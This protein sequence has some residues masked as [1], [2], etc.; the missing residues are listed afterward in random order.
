MAIVS[1]LQLDHPSLNTTGGSSL[2]T[3]IEN[4]YIKIGDNLNSRFFRVENLNDGNHIDLEHNFK[5]SFSSLQFDLYTWNPG[6]DEITLVS[7]S[8]L[9]NYIIV[10]K[11]GHLT[12]EIRV[13]NNSG[14]TQ[15]LVLVVTHGVLS[16]KKID[17][18]IKNISSNATLEQGKYHLVD[19]SATRILTLPDPA[20]TTKPIWVK[21]KTGSALDYPIHIQRHNTENIETEAADYNCDY[22]LGSWTFITDGTDWFIV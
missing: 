13:T 12:T 1:R 4:L 14:F 18:V 11:P 19:T 5:A 17:F 2:H 22:N 21:D 6:T 9:E 15:D 16:S 3:A 7:E 10:P 8:D 20:L